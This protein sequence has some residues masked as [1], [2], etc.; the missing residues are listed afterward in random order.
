MVLFCCNRYTEKLY[1]EAGNFSVRFWYCYADIYLMEQWK[2]LDISSVWSVLGTGYFSKRCGTRLALYFAPI[3]ENSLDRSLGH[4]G[5]PHHI[6]TVSCY[7]SGLAP[8]SPFF[9]CYSCVTETG[10]PLDRF[11]GVRYSAWRSTFFG[12]AKRW[13]MLQLCY[14]NGTSF[15]FAKKC[16]IIP[17]SADT[18][19]SAAGRKILRKE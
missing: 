9:F 3:L 14:E 5:S 8:A 7:H 19:P 12:K 10:T 17:T 6:F 2:N 1:F 11:L 16:W 18:D 13:G 4:K 15:P